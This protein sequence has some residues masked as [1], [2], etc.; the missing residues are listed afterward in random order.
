MVVYNCWTGTSGLERW[1]GIVESSIYP[2]WRFINLE[3]DP[4]RMCTHMNGNSMV[5][6]QYFAL[7]THAFYK[8]GNY[9]Q[10]SIHTGWCRRFY[11][12]YTIVNKDKNKHTQ[13]LKSPGHMYMHMYVCW[14]QWHVG[15]VDWNCDSHTGGFFKINP[16]SQG[17]PLQSWIHDALISCHSFS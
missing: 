16:S 2:I 12:Y 4:K 17:L 13:K 1:T 15:T 10:H 9:S 11:D 7:Y 3:C 8:H 14:D 6:V 5:G